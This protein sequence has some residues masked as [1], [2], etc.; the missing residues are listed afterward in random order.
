MNSNFLNQK[1]S[2][3]GTSKASSPQGRASTKSSHSG[4]SIQGTSGFTQSIFRIAVFLVIAFFL[5]INADVNGQCTITP[6]PAVVAPTTSYCH[7][8]VIYL[9]ASSS[10]S[11]ADNI[12]YHWSTG[13]NYDTTILVLSSTSTYTVT[14]TDNSL[15]Q[16]CTQSFTVNV[17]NTVGYTIS[18]SQAAGSNNL[19]TFCQDQG[20]EL[21]AYPQ[22][23]TW[24]WSDNEVANSITYTGTAPGIF[25][26]T[27]VPSNNTCTDAIVLNVKPNPTPSLTSSVWRNTQGNFGF[28]PDTVCPNTTL[29]LSVSPNTYSSYLWPDGSNSSSLTF[30]VATPPS[31]I[32]FS[33]DPDPK[34]LITLIANSPDGCSSDTTF[35]IVKVPVAPSITS[36]GTLCPNNDSTLELI[37]HDANA[38]SGVNGYNYQW[39]G[40]SSF[41]QNSS[42]NIIFVYQ[43]G[44][45]S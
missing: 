18:S 1:G 21:Y 32:T 35:T 37:A 45:A 44:R 25:E 4:T 3:D 23:L 5:G 43:I 27:A 13:S 17:N 38:N 31:G 2:D 8:S 7:G 30:D 26:I 41:S 20:P 12:T 42:A 11:N 15:S 19:V 29:K 14:I 39:S 33:S 34:A 10:F 6:F 28:S 40:P 24:T 9:Q 16:S 22:N 36:L